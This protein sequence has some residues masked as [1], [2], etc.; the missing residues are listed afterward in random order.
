[1]YW[2]EPVMLMAPFFRTF[3]LAFLACSLIGC[4]T[5]SSAREKKAKVK[6]DSLRT[7]LM[8]KAIKSPSKSPEEQIGRFLNVAKLAS[9]TLENRPNH[10]EARRDYNFAVARVFEIVN[11]NNLKPWVTPLKCPGYDGDWVFSLKTDG[12]PIHNPSLFRILPADRYQFRGKLVKDR[13]VKEGIGAALITASHPDMDFT[14]KDPFIMGKRIYYGVTVLLKFDGLNCTAE[15]YDPLETEEVKLSGHTFPL[16]ADFTAPIALSLAELKP[17][18]EE[19]G[20]M[21]RPDEFAGTAR[22]ARLQTYDPKKIPIMCIHGLGDSQA[23]WAPMIETLRGDPEIRK[24]YQF[25]FFT[26]PTGYPYPV[27]ADELRRDMDAMNAAY[28][29]HKKFVVIGHSTGGMIA[30]ELMTDSHMTLWNAYF[31]VPPD[32]LPLPKSTRQIIEGALIFEHRKD[33]S[34]IILC[35]ASLRG[36]KT[37]VGF[38]GKLGRRLIGNSNTLLGSMDDTMKAVSLTKRPTVGK[39]LVAMPN[40]IDTLEPNNRFLSTINS[41]PPHPSIPYHSIIGDRG[42][43]GNLNTT[44]PVSTDG[45]VPYWSSHIDGA[46]SELIIPS[47]HWTNQH[48]QGIAEV[49]RI[50][51][52][53]AGR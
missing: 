32:K 4:N 37:A 45:L 17:R 36:S 44:K 9:I 19:I 23:T 14:K 16:A 42:K 24:H 29:G 26:F 28:P 5:Y 34:R 46:Q 49:R 33:V 40:S 38:V 52:D 21:F 1:M 8:L 3:A 47:G 27:M 11:D 13:T 30:R 12:N 31:D 53:H 22:L 6:K 41:I 10:E 35:S 20:R 2:L 15:Y 18:K 48:P 25:W 39:P 43:G 51:L 50:L 7:A